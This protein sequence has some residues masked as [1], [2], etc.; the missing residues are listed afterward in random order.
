MH[1]A[2]SIYLDHAGT[3]LYPKSLVDRFAHEMTTS[4]LGN[5]HSTS[6]SSQLSTLRIEDTRLRAL[7]LFGA[8]PTEFDLI[9]VANATAGIKLVVEALRARSEGFDF[10][11]HQSS[12]TSLVGVREEAQ[13]SSCLDDNQIREWLS[14]SDSIADQ[15]KPSST[16]LFA[17]PGQSNMDGRRYPLAWSDQVR[18]HS[19]LDGIS[20]FTLLDAASLAATAP[21]FLGNSES[22][23]DFTVVSF[24]K[25]FGFPD[26]GGLL[27]RR[28]AESAFTNR[29][30]FGGG[31]VE[32]VVCN[33]EQWHA[34]K[35]YNLHE[36]LEDGTLPIHNIM[37]LDIAMLVHRELFGSLGCVASHVS[38][39][40]KRL[41]RGLAGLRHVNGAPV[42]EM[43]SPDESRQY[44]TG[45]IKEALHSGPIIAFNIRNQAGACIS[46]SEVEKLA[47]LKSFHI[48]T[49]GVCNPGGI[50]SALKLQPWEIKRNFSVGFRCGSEND[51]IAGKPTGVIRAS[52][53]AMSTISDVDS[54]IAFVSEFYCEQSLPIEVTS[55]R[56]TGSPV[57][58]DLHVSDIIVYP[59]KSCGGFTIPNNV[60]WEV[61]P[62]G[63]AWDREWCLLHQGTGQ[64][65]SQ[66]RYNNMALIR[67]TLDFEAGLLRVTYTG[68]L[69]D[70]NQSR[71]ISVPLSSNP[72]LFQTNSTPTVTANGTSSHCPLPSRVCGDEILTQ[73]Y[74]SE[75]IMNFFT[76]ALGVPCM[77]AR[78]P[79]GGQEGNKSARHAKAH[80]QKH[81]ETYY[82]TS[83]NIHVARDPAISTAATMPSSPPDSDVEKNERQRI[84]LSNESPILTIN[85]ASLRALNRDIVN[86]G[87]KEVSP[88][89]FRANIVLD[90]ASA[91]S[92]PVSD[93]DNELAYAEDNWCRIR[94]GQQDFK[95]LG[96]CRRCHMVC[97][98]Q[99]TAEKGEE[100]F[101]TL[102]KTRRFNGKV[103]FGTHMCHVKQRPLKE[104]SMAT[105]EGQHPTVRI[106]AHVTIEK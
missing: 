18:G 23:P 20:C 47:S 67:P 89:V 64:A 19:S 65:L 62:E 71:E 22:A 77:L 78:F 41:Q 35:A 82:T 9:F 97:V 13:N 84:L 69:F 90:S 4:L 21:L 75:E 79:P 25:I 105:R 53:G 96:S 36:R 60:D 44:S 55:E 33:R 80:L 66:K 16:V 26:L 37:A 48:R 58:A 87:G 61:R 24:A 49:G 42:C 102:S 76:A 98:N 17:Y 100:P 6:P 45:K 99:D 27:V 43:Y 73:T 68:K 91:S 92:G 95:M 106:G 51:I 54:F 8:D 103:F 14:G 2:G 38:F 56:G 12:H 39:L 50:A 88:A 10:I 31:T 15:I 101:V 83:A 81:Q 57:E 86:R 59:I 70:P 5:P 1:S 7:Q 32:T 11:Y 40:S 72:T 3:T 30:Y 93:V 29:R 74:A 52:L 104:T 28:Q 34:P 94:I 63:L 46:L 85:M